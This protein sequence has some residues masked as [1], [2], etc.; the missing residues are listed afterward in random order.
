M[1][2]R[3]NLFTDNYNTFEEW[4]E[5]RQNQQYGDEI[6]YPQFRIP[7]S[8]WLDEYIANIDQKSDFEVKK[9]LRVLLSSF[10]L[11]M[12][13]SSY[14]GLVT[15]LLDVEN[16][17]KDSELYEKM[18]DGFF[19]IEKN[20]RIGN[21]R[22]AWEGLTWV[23]GLLPYYPIK[24]M[25]ALNLYFDAECTSMPDDRFDSLK[26]SI[27]IIEAKFIKNIKGLEKFILELQPRQFEYLIAALYQ[28]MGYHIYLTPETR[29]GGK[30]VI[31]SIAN[32]GREEKIYAECKLYKNSA[33]KKDTVRAFGYT[34]NRDNVNRGV[35]F[36]MGYVSENLKKMDNRIQIYT[37]DET[38]LLLNANMGRIWYEKFD[39]LCQ[40]VDRNVSFK[41]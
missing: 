4:L 20:R 25:N 9:L 40:R 30:D 10:T 28:Q 1:K 23:L 24:A 11:G 29:D 2:E 8:E 31:A 38:I 35:M 7:F 32:N 14:E 16:R 17:N 5:K 21:S 15:Y 19:N 12:D 18:L 34:I 22:E 13:V 36:C 6:V 41:V 26:Q 33:L 3:P 37:L 39:L 27:A